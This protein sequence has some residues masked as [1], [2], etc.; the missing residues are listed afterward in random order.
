MKH[1]FGGWAVVAQRLRGRAKPTNTEAGQHYLNAGQRASLEAIANRIGDNGMIIADEVGM[2]KTRI[3]CVLAK[4]VVEAGGRV[5]ILVPPGLGFQWQKELADA[6]LRV[7]DLL[8]SLPSYYAAWD[9][10][11]TGPWFDHPALLMSHAF[12]DWR[13]GPRSERSGLLPELI[14]RW[15]KKEKGKFP[16]HYDG[17]AA[18]DRPWGGRA[19]VSIVGAVPAVVRNPA[20]RF[21]DTIDASF[22]WTELCNGEEYGRDGRLR[23]ALERAVGLGLGSFDLVIIDEAHKSRRTDSALSTMLDSV[24]AMGANARRVG[25][26]AT[27]VE[28]TPQQWWNTLARIGVD[29]FAFTPGSQQ[30]PIRRYADAVK[31]LRR[32]WRSSPV[33]RT[34]YR[35]A[36]IAFQKTLGPFL[37]RRDKREDADVQLFGK[38]SNLPI[39]YYRRRR[40]IIVEP[41][42]LSLEWRRAVCAV[43]ALSVIQAQ[44][45]AV[46]WQHKRLRQTVG[47]GHGIAGL[48]DQS[49]ANAIEDEAQL[50]LD[51]ETAA[52]AAEPTSSPAAQDESAA[53]PALAAGS[54]DEK[55]AARAR[56]W[57]GVVTATS[58][59][60]GDDALYAHPAL[61]AAV[62]R[63][64]ETTQAGEKVLVFGRFT[65]PL[66]ALTNLLNARAML[67]RI[68]S[69]QAWPHAKVAGDAAANTGEWPAVRAAYRQLNKGAELDEAGAAN[70]DDILRRQYQVLERERERFREGLLGRLAEGL[71]AHG[72]ASDFAAAVEEA[73]SNTPSTEDT[74]VLARALLELLPHETTQQASPVQLA[75]TLLDLVRSALDHDAN[76]ASDEEKDARSSWKNVIDRLAEDFARREG[77]F[78]R[79]MYGKTEPNS[80]RLLQLAFNRQHSFPQVLVAQSVVGREGL[81]LHEAC[82][83]VVILHPEWNPGVVEQQIGRV[84][85]LG[86][87][88]SKLLRQA[89]E[90]PDP[91]DIPFIDVCPVIFQGTYDGEHWRILQERWD[92]LRAQLHGEPIPPRLAGDDPEAIAIVRAL[93]ADA[94]DFSPT[95]AQRRDPVTA[96]RSR[97]P[98]S[99][100]DDR[101]YIVQNGPGF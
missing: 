84:D 36:A 25:L 33:A 47:N 86:S 95:R 45:G 23:P 35:E 83:T 29:R 7:P 31:N 68:E 58:N 55:R 11:G 19:A 1:A 37:L 51:A 54:A 101:T 49:L 17:E 76:G 81:N 53:A 70:I 21:L 48:I 39:D 92:D 91:K 24:L 94:P 6:G 96:N 10:D 65:R 50:E 12:A 44:A 97:D 30:D 32:T 26:T 62:Q 16:D 60:A 80:R 5:A 20:R 69:G 98:R 82:R 42:S 9:D 64:E 75:V 85:R 3:A 34:E 79:L 77:D 99:P 56:W 93:A 14:A 43:E 100:L 78:A 46:N 87:H 41:D 40:E 63:I 2:G 66:R 4:C 72:A 18:L 59:G 38:L 89:A 71:R 52:E 22:T 15:R 88:W 67:R 13:L 73:A 90:Q 28:L 57:S 27:P 61:C 74:I 8:R